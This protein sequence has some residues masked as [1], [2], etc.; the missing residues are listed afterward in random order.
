MRNITAFFVAI[1][2]IFTCSISS[3]AEQ[4]QDGEEPAT[5]HPETTEYPN[6]ISLQPD[7]VSNS[8]IVMDA[9]TGKILFEKNAYDRKY[10][11][12]ITKII[13]VALALEQNPDFNE[14]I[15]MSENAIWGV[16]RNSSLIGL[17]VG[18]QVSLGDLFYATMVNSANE[19][20][21]ALAEYVA[22][23]I[24]SFAK[25]MNAKAEEIG[26]QDTHFVTPNGLPDENHY[27]TAYDMALITRYA[28]Q[29]DQF[30]EIAGTLF[31]EVPATNLTDETRPL[32]NGNKMINPSEPYYYE[33]CEG[34]K[35][36]YTTVSNNTLVTY[37]KK[38]GLELICVIMDCDGAKYAYTDSKALYN[39][40]YNNY[41][42]F[43]P[44]SDF[45]FETQ[46]DAEETK[47]VL[48][49]NFYDSLDHDLVDLK[50]DNNYSLLV[51]KSLDTTKIEHS[52]ILYDEQQ[53][54][55]LGEIQFS[56]EGEV[57][58]ST[59]ITTSSPHFSP[60]LNTSESTDTHS[61]FK[62]PFGKVL[63]VILIVI[64]S[65]LCILV[66]YLILS[67]LIWNAKHGG[68][69]HR[70]YGSHEKRKRKRRSS[71]KRKRNNDYYF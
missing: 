49:E 4:L 9:A 59:L 64:A 51:N 15:T 27:T 24:E 30:R 53:N 34:G 68:R 1:L 16:D 37:A 14:T 7:L 46:A 22:G 25:L 42:Y 40:C 57:M 5:E 50:V 6:D 52:V 35:T 71:G 56:Y 67:K 55:A 60:R 61:F 17:D 13:T 19:C 36:G 8:A 69:R 2:L 41:T 66:L 45:Y 29:N 31:Y 39:Y 23:D 28:L 44:L 70:R 10:P 48:L 58:G 62:K 3:F 43:Y 38:D 65:L 11:A 18:E 47:N 12:S 26:C 32:W 54:N 21:Y 20:A 33:Y 63:Y